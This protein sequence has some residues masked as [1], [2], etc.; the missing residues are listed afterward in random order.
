MQFSITFPLVFTL[1]IVA[2]VTPTLT[3]SQRQDEEVQFIADLANQLNE[4]II[5]TTQFFEAFSTLS[6]SA[7]NTQA[8]VAEGALQDAIGVMGTI[9]QELSNNTMAQVIKGGLLDNDFLLDIS[10]QLQD[11]A[12]GMNLDILAKDFYSILTNEHRSTK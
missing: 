4:D 7:L 12:E 10:L 9:T 11:F 6:G 1:V 8:S 2:S 5:H 3:I